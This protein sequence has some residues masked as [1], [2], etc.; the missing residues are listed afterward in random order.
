MDGV[1][2]CDSE[3]TA[4]METYTKEINKILQ[5]S[6]SKSQSIFSEIFY[7]SDW[8]GEQKA[9]FCS[10]MA[11]ILQYHGRLN[12]NYG[13]EGPPAQEAENTVSQFRNDF[14]NFMSSSQLWNKLN[15]I[16]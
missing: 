3:F 13:I 7:S 1:F 16:E 11:L 8:Q 5:E 12:G 14:D 9:A 6:Y 2:K 10:W 15:E 4:N